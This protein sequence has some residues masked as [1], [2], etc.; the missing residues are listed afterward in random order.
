MK[1]AERLKDP[2]QRARAKKEMDDPNAPWQN[3]WLGS[4]RLAT[5]RRRIVH[6]QSSF[7]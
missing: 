7:R 2:A 4:G 3:Q 1:M 6:R 5:A